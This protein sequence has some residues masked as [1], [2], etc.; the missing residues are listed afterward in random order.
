MKTLNTIMKEKF[1]EYL[2]QIGT[3]T[4]KSMKLTELIH[5]CKIN[6]SSAPASVVSKLTEIAAQEYEKQNE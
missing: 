1:H 6:N 4:R 3:Q 5:L 2:N